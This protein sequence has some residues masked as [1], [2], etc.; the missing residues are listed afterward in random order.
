MFWLIEN[1]EQLQTFKEKGFKKV[2]IEPLFSNDNTHPYLRGIVGFYIREINHRKG[3]IINV[4]HSEATSCELDEI[5]NVI[6]G[7]EEIFVTDKKEFLHIVPLKQ[8]SD[9][10]F[11]HPTD[12][13]DQFP[14]HEFFYRKYPHIA[15]IGSII[16]IVKHYERCETIYN[17]V[18]HVFAMEK[19]PHFEFYNNKA[20][21]VFYWIEAN[22]LKVDPKLFEEHFGVERDWTYSQ[23]NLKTTTTRPSNSFGGINYAALDKKS[24]CREAFI[25]ENNF[26]LEI[27]ISAYHPTLAA[28]LVN[29]DF[30][31]GD[32]HQAFA[33]MYG[34]DYKK[35]KELTFKQLYGGVF[36]EYKDLEFFKRVEKYIEDI[37]SKEEVVCK[38]GYVFKTD[39]K[40]QKLFNYI[41]QN[42]ETYYNVL[43]LEEIIRTLKHCETRIVHYTYDS[44]LLDVSKDEKYVVLSILAI[45]KK[46]GFSTKV[47]AGPNYNNLQRV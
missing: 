21:N 17:A 14:C 18:K 46:Y 1:K 30:G 7:F 33:D 20:T 2:F 38:S 37:S 9:I 3:F 24:G 42:T 36:K 41:L 26:L 8:L 10:H 32:I 11:I 45:F 12:I 5:L 34:V 25:P 23:F 27:D 47:E 29:F 22:G 13:P 16:P 4:N 28:Q 44:F 39:M 40:P 15:N 6:G 35:A 19:P 43:I 31:E